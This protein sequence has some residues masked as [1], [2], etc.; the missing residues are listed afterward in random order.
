MNGKTREQEIKEFEKKYDV[1]VTDRKM[2]YLIIAINLITTV[3]LIVSLI[4]QFTR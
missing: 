2:E 3:L 4:I 1:I